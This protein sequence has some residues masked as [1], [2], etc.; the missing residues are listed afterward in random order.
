MFRKLIIVA[1]P[2]MVLVLVLTQ[3]TSAR[4][5]RNFFAPE[6]DAIGEISHGGRFVEVVALIECTEGERLSVDVTL[7]QGSE[8]LGDDASNA[9]GRGHGFAICD[10]EGDLTEVPVRVI[11]QGRETFVE[12]TARATGLAITTERGQRTDVR[13][14]QPGAGIELVSN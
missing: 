14:W 12:G 8:E 11:A 4:M 6:N 2:L 10:G 7:S 5:F 1:V 9:L 13:Q 3:A